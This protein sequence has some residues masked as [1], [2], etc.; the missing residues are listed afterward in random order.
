MTK[1]NWPA[2]PNPFWFATGRYALA[3][4]VVQSETTVTTEY[5]DLRLKE[6]V[7]PPVGTELVIIK[8]TYWLD[9]EIRTE[10]EARKAKEAVEREEQRRVRLEESVRREREC[11]DRVFNK[12]KEVNGKLNIP[13]RW[14]SG[15]KPVLSGL[16]EHSWG[17]GEKRSTVVHILILESV[18]DGRF[19]RP[20]DNFLCTASS[21]SNGKQWTEQMHSHLSNEDGP[22][23]RE[24]TCKQCLKV[25]MRW[26]NS[27]ERVAPE[28]IL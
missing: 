24:I 21:G 20:A 17:N 13:V 2:H 11:Q 15:I 10:Y 6:G 12:A 22:F 28:V 26:A 8:N 1:L 3:Y 9:A 19:V 5:G 25:A 18:K 16:S 7:L 4:G 14:T 27:A 23:V